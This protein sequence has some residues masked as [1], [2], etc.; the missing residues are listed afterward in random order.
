MEL[1]FRAPGR[2]AVV[3]AEDIVDGFQKA[4]TAVG[5]PE[6]MELV[7]GDLDVEALDDQKFVAGTTE[8]RFTYAVGGVRACG[9]QTYFWADRI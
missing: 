8:Y 6:M 9:R 1:T 3:Q 7:V 5:F 2:R 4:V